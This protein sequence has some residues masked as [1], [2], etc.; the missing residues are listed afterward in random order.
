MNLEFLTIVHSGFSSVR[1]LFFCYVIV[2]QRSFN[3]T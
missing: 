3:A 1:F 2:A